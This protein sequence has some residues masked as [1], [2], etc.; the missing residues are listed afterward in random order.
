MTARRRRFGLAAVAL[1]G[2]LCLAVASPSSTEAAWT[3]TE[4][5]SSTALR[6]G[7]VAPVTIMSCQTGALGTS[8][9]TFTWTPPAAGAGQLAPTGYRYTV[10]G[11]FTTSGT[12]GST[13]T[14]ISFS[15]GLLGLGSGTFS[16]YATVGNWD[17]PA[18]T[19][20]LAFLTG[21]LASCSVP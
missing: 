2:I 6:A 8:P 4:V 13:A 5:G 11:G 20:S 3:D 12:L 14:T 9:V 7:S 18:K 21:L 17:S 19:G 15:T 1:A 16:L 10:T